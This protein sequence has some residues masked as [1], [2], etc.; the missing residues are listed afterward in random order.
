MSKIRDGIVFPY[1]IRLQEN[2]T[3]DTFPIVEIAFPYK[4]GEW[5]SL[6]LVIDSGA[7]ISALPKSDAEMFGISLDTGIRLLISGVGGEKIVGWKYQITARLGGKDIS[8]PVVFIDNEFSPRVLGR[9]GIFNR[10]TIIFE[11]NRQRT[12]FL[13]NHTN[14]AS[15]IQKILDKIHS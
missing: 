3:I 12:G 4:K 10:F 14:Q 9:A 15:H 6:F 8:F 11:E 2:G 13:E 5:I 7:T 1:N